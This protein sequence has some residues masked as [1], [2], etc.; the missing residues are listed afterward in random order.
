MSKNIPKAF[1]L[2]ELLVVIAIIGIL[3]TLAIVAL[4]NSRF[5]A[6]D[7][8][9]L[10]DA[11]SIV[12]ALELYYADNNQY[13]SS[14]TPGQPL[15]ANDI[16]YISKV[17]NNPT[18]RTDGD[19]PNEEYSY[20]PLDNQQD[21]VI[22]YCLGSASSSS[23]SGTVVLSS[24]GPIDPSLV[25][26]WKFEEGSGLNT[27]DSSGNGNNGTL[28][29][30]VTWQPENECRIG[31]CLRFTSSTQNVNVGN[32][33]SLRITENL[34]VAFWI[35]PIAWQA[36]VDLINNGLY[37]FRYRGDWDVD[38]IRF[39]YMIQEATWPGCS[40]WTYWAGSCATT[41]TFSTLDTWYHVAGVKRGDNLE[42]WVN[43]QMIGNNQ[44]FN[45]HNVSDSQFGNL[46]FRQFNGYMDEV[47]IY[48]R[49]LSAQ[50]ISLIRFAQ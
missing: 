21:Y 5:K 25:G 44:I 36:S 24:S 43:G 29:A 50:E 38:N 17:P 10:N 18:P 45:N 30:G 4:G 8:K 46:L 22:H 32:D 11:R 2:I 1:T 20:T 34:T 41:S 48:N 15:E 28:S 26:F 31:S 47:R 40:A 37:R 23:E 13:P 16:V 14:L 7:S 19:C 39:L 6:R 35:R 12:N 33:N 9:R 3:S 42:F 27:Q 49:S